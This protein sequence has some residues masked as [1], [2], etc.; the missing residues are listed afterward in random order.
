MRLLTAMS[1]KERLQRPVS[2]SLMM[3]A[4]VIG[5][6]FPAFLRAG[7]VTLPVAASTTG[8]GGV[9]FVSD[10]RVFNTSYTNVMNVTAVY[11]FNGMTQVFQQVQITVLS[12]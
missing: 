8:V 1:T 3:L 5:S 7:T 4:V 11:R 2:L 9:P 10:V 6:G 12:D